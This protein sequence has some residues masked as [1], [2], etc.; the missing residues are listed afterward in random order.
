[1]STSCQEVKSLPDFAKQAAKSVLEELEAMKKAAEA[2]IRGKGSFDF[3]LADGNLLV[4]RLASA[5]HSMM[6]P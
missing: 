2:C 1:M 4:P 6:T 5:G 3:Q